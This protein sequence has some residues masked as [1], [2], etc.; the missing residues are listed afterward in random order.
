MQTI[1]IIRLPNGQVTGAYEARAD[2]EADA[3]ALSGVATP[4]HVVP[5]RDRYRYLCDV[6][7]EEHRTA[8]RLAPGAVAPCERH[9]RTF[10]A[11]A[12]HPTDF[13]DNGLPIGR[14]Y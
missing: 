3:E 12:G 13:L 9:T 7:G 10:R 6:C 14:W 8:E 2:A 11:I 4:R 1:W 5:R